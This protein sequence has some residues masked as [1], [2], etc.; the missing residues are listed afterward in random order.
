[1]KK[2]MIISLLLFS[3]LLLSG[4]ESKITAE[5]LAPINSEEVIKVF[6]NQTDRGRDY[7][8]LND[9]VDLEYEVEAGHEVYGFVRT[10]AIDGLEPD[11]NVFRDNT[12]CM[13]LSV[14]VDKSIKY[15][16]EEY[17]ELSRAKKI[18]ISPQENAHTLRFSTS[19]K[20]PL[21][22]RMY[23]RKVSFL[24]RFD[25]QAIEDIKI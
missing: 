11:L 23:S 12:L 25:N 19:G 17:S 3:L 5:H 14:F 20:L 22:I 10:V 15:T 21:M 24:D 6:N 7:Y 16:S 9:S 1:M 13:I 18:D 4:T 2:I 8:I